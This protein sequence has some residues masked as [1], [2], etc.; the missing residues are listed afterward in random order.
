MSVLLDQDTV[1]VVNL[2]ETPM[3]ECVNATCETPAAAR[4]IVYCACRKMRL[5]CNHHIA[6]TAEWFDTHR[7]VCKTCG[8]ASPRY[9]VVPL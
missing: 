2:D 1:V 5:G 3:C 6:A 8:A 4:F 7:T 9:Q